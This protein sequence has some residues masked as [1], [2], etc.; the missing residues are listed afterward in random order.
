MQMGLRD[1]G[2]R[3]VEIA[4]APDDAGLAL[5]VLGPADVPAVSDGADMVSESKMRGYEGLEVLVALIRALA[6][7]PPEAGA[8]AMDVDVHGEDLVVE[9]IHQDA[10]RDL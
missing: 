4:V 9:G 5:R 3:S 1:A 6:A 2:A 8:D 10:L 7:G